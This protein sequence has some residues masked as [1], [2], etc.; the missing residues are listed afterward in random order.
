MIQLTNFFSK[1]QNAFRSNNLIVKFPS[2]KLTIN[3]AY[4]LQER[5]FLKR[6]ILNESNFYVILRYS[7]SIPALRKIQQISTPSKSF[8]WS[9]SEFPNFGCFLITT[10]KGIEFVDSESKPTRGGKVLCRIY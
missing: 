9:R 2:S 8:F 7:N 3:A 4:V 6:I 1:L 5:G 10:S